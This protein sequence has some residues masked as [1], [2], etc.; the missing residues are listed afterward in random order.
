VGLEGLDHPIGKRHDSFAGSCFWFNQDKSG[1]GPLAILGINVAGLTSQ[2]IPDGK[3]GSIEVEIGPLESERLT[4]AQARTQ[5]GEIK[6]RQPVFGHRADQLC[7]LLGRGTDPHAVAGLLWF[8]WAV[9][10]SNL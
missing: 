1:A 2:L 9:Q 6:P 10:D 5:H 3:D 7:D 8:W 4:A